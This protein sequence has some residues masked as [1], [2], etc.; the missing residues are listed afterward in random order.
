MQERS[1]RGSRKLK[2]FDL[3]W[4]EYQ[5][6]LELQDHRC[7]ICGLHETDTHGQGVTR[8]LAVD[9]CHESGRVRQLLC[10]RCNKALGLMQDNPQRLRDAARYIEQH[11][12]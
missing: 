12:L 2:K 10:G 11:S 3:T 5:A 8:A 1:V 9:H 4:D 7:A 6:M